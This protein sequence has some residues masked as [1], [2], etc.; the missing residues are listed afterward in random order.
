M[1]GHVNMNVN[2]GFYLKDEFLQKQEFTP[3]GV[4]PQTFVT[5]KLQ[6]TLSKVVSWRLL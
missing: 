5:R 4:G 3:M 2:V 6:L 1:N